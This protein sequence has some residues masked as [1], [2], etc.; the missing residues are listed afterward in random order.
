[1]NEEW[2][3]QEK[4]DFKRAGLSQHSAR[5]LGLNSPSMKIHSSNTSRLQQ[6]ILYRSRRVV[7]SSEL[8]QSNSSFRI[9]RHGIMAVS[10][11]STHG[12][13]KT[14]NGRLGSPWFVIG[15]AS[16]HDS[17][18]CHFYGQFVAVQSALN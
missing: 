8:S 15:L 14:P 4:E 3:K 11:K 18:A 6:D 1:M 13:T 17:R 10:V 5:G 9:L 12:P 16:F 7:L 2:E